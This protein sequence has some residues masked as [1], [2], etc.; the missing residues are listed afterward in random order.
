MVAVTSTP[1]STCSATMLILLEACVAATTTS[2]FFEDLTS[3]RP[4]A[5]FWRMTT[6]R[7]FTA[8]CLSKRWGA[9]C[10]KEEGKRSNQKPI[11]GKIRRPIVF[12]LM[13]VST[14]PALHHHRYQFRLL[15]LTD[16]QLFEHQLAPRQ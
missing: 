7:P 13:L 15:L 6:G 10:T 11:A 3:M 16:G 1:S 12:K 5:T 4:L 8:K 2:G 9:A 14:P